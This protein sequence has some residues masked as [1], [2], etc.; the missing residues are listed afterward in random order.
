MERTLVLPPENDIITTSE[1]NISDNRGIILILDLLK[2][3]KVIGY[4]HYDTVLSS[5]WIV[6]IAGEVDEFYETL[7]DV[8]NFYELDSVK[9]KYIT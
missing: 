1:V 7:E 8:L 3:N 4:V 2:G 5:P 6:K 9:F